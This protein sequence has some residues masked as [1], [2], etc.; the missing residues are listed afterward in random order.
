VLGVGDEISSSEMVY[1]NDGFS[2]EDA[3]KLMRTFSTAKQ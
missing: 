1:S 3:D 2:A